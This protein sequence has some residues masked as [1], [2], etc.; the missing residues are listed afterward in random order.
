VNK[1]LHVFSKEGWLPKG[2]SGLLLCCVV[3]DWGRTSR[4]GNEVRKTGNKGFWCNPS[5]GEKTSDRKKKKYRGAWHGR[6]GRS[7]QAAV[8]V[9]GS[10][11]Y[12]GE[13]K[14]N[15]QG[16][17]QKKAAVYKKRHRC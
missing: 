2:T 12:L 11:R 9:R 15:S 16:F 7:L 6:E 17:T 10:G 4:D 8:G 3:R 13:R 1:N 5:I 14:K